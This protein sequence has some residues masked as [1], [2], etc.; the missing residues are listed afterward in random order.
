MGLSIM[1]IIRKTNH[2]VKANLRTA[3]AK[4]IR[5]GGSMVSRKEKDSGKE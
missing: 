2:K 4:Y 1:G 5:G 3:K